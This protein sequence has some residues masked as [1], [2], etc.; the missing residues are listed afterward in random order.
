MSLHQDTVPARY[1]T[2]FHAKPRTFSALRRP[3]R[4]VQHGIVTVSVKRILSPRFR[5]RKLSLW[6]LAA[7]W[8][9]LSE[10]LDGKPKWF[11]RGPCRIQD[12]TCWRHC[13][14]FK[15]GS[16]A[17]S[18]DNVGKDAL[19]TRRPKRKICHT[20]ILHTI[21]DDFILSARDVKNERIQ[22]L[23]TLGTLLGAYRNNSIIRWTH[24]VDVAVLNST[25]SS[26]VI[27][28]L[29][30]LLNKK[31]YILFHSGIWRVCIGSWHRIAPLIYNAS[32]GKSYKP[33]FH[34]ETP[35]LDIY[36][37]DKVDDSNEYF[38]MQ[39]LK[40]VMHSSVI[41]PFRNVSILGQS[42]ETFQKPT[43]F[44]GLAG[45]GNFMIPRIEPHKL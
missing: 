29:T 43:V 20:S 14:P 28:E 11:R 45:Y 15:G 22:P 1:C 39:T 21:L 38:K 4:W 19:P 36:I 6:L 3:V 8:F 10:L 12:K 13:L 31:G 16:E 18:C 9:F 5:P 17:S 42:Y 23:L 40:Q 26:E 30:H 41:F 32:A 7:T 33:G 44:F 35:Y 25:W 37:I 27:T 34:G 2:E 24:D